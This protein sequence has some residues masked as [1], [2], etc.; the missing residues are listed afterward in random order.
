M[1]NYTKRSKLEARDIVHLAAQLRCKLTKIG[2]DLNK[3]K[4]LDRLPVD[5]ADIYLICSNYIALIQSLIE[6][7]NLQDTFQTQSII[8]EIQQ[9]LYV[10]L[11]SHYKPLAQ[12]L[13]KA[14]K[15]IEPDKR[16][17]QNAKR[18]YIKLSLEGFGM[19]LELPD[20]D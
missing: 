9:N 2:I 4:P 11:P 10:H 1:E 5:L 13:E 7:E 20:E 3:N 14:L 17:R 19:E 6:L 18:K 15:E 16:K 12:G 8:F